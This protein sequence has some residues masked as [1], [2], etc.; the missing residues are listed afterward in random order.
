[1]FNPFKKKAVSYIFSVR[2]Y[3][4]TFEVTTADGEIF[5]TNRKDYIHI[6]YEWNSSRN[7]SLEE[8]TASKLLERG[9]KEGIKV[10]ELDNPIYV[11]PIRVEEIYKKELTLLESWSGTYRP[12][13][14]SK[15]TFWTKDGIRIDETT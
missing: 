14:S 11:Q 6:G 5:F 10:N 3:G 13:W 15:P 7:L 2:G 12:F 8:V 4:R 1:M 9:I